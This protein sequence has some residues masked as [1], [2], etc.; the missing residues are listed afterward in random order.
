MISNEE[1]DINESIKDQK[2]PKFN[3]YKENDSYN[4][5]GNKVTIK[6]NKITLSGIPLTNEERKEMEKTSKNKIDRIGGSIRRKKLVRRPKDNRGGKEL[7]KLKKI[8][9]EKEIDL[10]EISEEGSN[11]LKKDGKFCTTDMELVAKIKESINNYENK[12]IIEKQE[13]EKEIIGKEDK[14]IIK[15]GKKNKLVKINEKEIKDE[16]KIIKEK[17]FN[18]NEEN[19]EEKNEEKIGGEKVDK[20]EEMIEENREEKKEENKEEKKEKENEEKKE[21]NKEEKKEKENEKKKK[22]KIKK[23]KK[24]KKKN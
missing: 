2:Q 22:K 18:I 6:S 13:K 19:K 8:N 23:K 14:E 24:E 15:G 1:Q 21:E 11:I 4:Y 5:D 12:K 20:N 16:I 17:E 10:D 7:K 3:K 9:K